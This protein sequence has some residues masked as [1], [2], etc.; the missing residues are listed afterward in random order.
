[1]MA[2]TQTPQSISSSGQGYTGANEYG[3]LETHPSSNKAW[4]PYHFNTGQWLTLTLEEP[5]HVVAIETRGSPDENYYVTGYAM[6]Y[7]N[8]TSGEWAFYK[9][10]V[11]E[12]AACTKNYF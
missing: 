5:M 11:Q 10:R 9:V 1:M 6:Q 3:D 8:A 2:A 7:L 12:S 4:R